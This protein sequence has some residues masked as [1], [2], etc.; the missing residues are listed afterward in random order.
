MGVSAVMQA[1]HDTWLRL[2]DIQ[3][4]AE[5][6]LGGPIGNDVKIHLVRD[7][8]PNKRMF[9]ISFTLPAAVAFYKHGDAAEADTD[10]PA[11]KKCKT[12]Q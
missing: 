3:R 5:G 11:T 10:E 8:A 2:A 7:V 12:A 9:C 1:L 4:R 6:Y